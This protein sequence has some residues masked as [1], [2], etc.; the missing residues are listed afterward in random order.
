[1]KIQLLYFSGCPSYKEGEKNLQQAMKELGLDDDFEMI[2]I[3]TD[4][5]ATEYQFIGSPTI[6]INGQ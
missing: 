4:K 6:R 2:N 5:M 3:E 1:M